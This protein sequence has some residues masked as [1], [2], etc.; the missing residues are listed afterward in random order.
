MHRR[1]LLKTILVGSLGAITGR[2]DKV[3]GAAWHEAARSRCV[4]V[5]TGPVILRAEPSLGGRVVG[6]APAGTC[7][8]MPNQAFIAADGYSWVRVTLDS[9][10]P[11]S[12][13]PT[14]YLTA[15]SP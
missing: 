7:G 8:T 3:T 11:D 1:Q 5:E 9:S 15:L 4:R 13:V 6:V 10:A 14:W 12:W 2:G